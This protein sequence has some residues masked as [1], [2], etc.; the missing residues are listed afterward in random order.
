MKKIIITGASGF[1][2]SNL[3]E[4]FIDNGYDVLNI[5][6]QRPKN[7]DFVK[8]WK[9]IDITNFIQFE[10]EVNSFDPDYIV[11]LAARTDLSG[12]A[13]ND[14]T[15]NTNG[16]ENLMTISKK[17]STLKKVLITS[18]M[19]VC[20][21]GYYPK[22]QLDFNPSTIYG[23]SKVITEKNVWANTPSCDWAIIRPSSIWGPEFDIP[24]KTFF[25][26]IRHKKYFHIGDRGCTKT[27]GY[28]ENVNY[29]I[30][31]ILFTDTTEDINKVYNLGDYEPTNIE[32]WANQI[33]SQ[34]GYGI[35]KVPYFL[36]KCSAFV[37]DFLGWFKINFPINSFR[38]K[39]MT[40]NNILDMSETKKIAPNLPFDR[41]NSIK[42]TLEW[43]NRIN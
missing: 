22:N 12:L 28:V 2:G 16:V 23:Q 26:M 43:L 35:K 9:N 42:R 1:I 34:L 3:L 27:Y 39:N 15:A 33:G 31:R 32:V 13:I 37:G 24:Y 41:V 38:L 21:P 18:S 30:E 7:K 17:L 29:Q 14:Y 8:H 11:H 36:I 10:S 25:D 19:L 6:F 4:K 20:R 40:T 5:D